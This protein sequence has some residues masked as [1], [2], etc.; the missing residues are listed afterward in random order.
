MSL[1]KRTDDNTEETKLTKEEDTQLNQ[2]VSDILNSHETKIHELSTPQLEKLITFIGS[3]QE[4][5]E[6]TELKVEDGKAQNQAVNTEQEELIPLTSELN[7]QQLLMKKD[8]EKFSNEDMGLANIK[9]KIVKG[10]VHRVEGNRVYIKV[11]KEN[12]TEEEMYKLI[13]YLDKTIAEP[14]NLYFNEFLYDDGQLSFRISRLDAIRHH[15]DKRVDSASGVAQAVYKR[16]KDIQTLSG[17]QIDEAGIGSGEVTNDST[18]SYHHICFRMLFQSKGG[19]A[20]EE[21]NIPVY[22]SRNKI[23]G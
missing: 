18:I 11:G 1:D 21:L 8:P 20:E 12:I 16:R 7:A 19:W 4:N 6:Q 14:N 2:Y 10:D 17:V 9:H 13:S 22:S 15:N 5:L 23:L 3:L